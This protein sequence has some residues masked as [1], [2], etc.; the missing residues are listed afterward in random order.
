[1]AIKAISS[2]GANILGFRLPGGG[3][4]SGTRNPDGGYTP[5]IRRIIIFYNTKK[6]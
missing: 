6:Y 1:M 5:D 4:A 2:G 3:P